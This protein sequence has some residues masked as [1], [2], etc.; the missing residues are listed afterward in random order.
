MTTN[1]KN[2]AGIRNGLKVGVEAHILNEY[3]SRYKSEAW[4]SSIGELIV[5][6]AG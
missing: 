4:E 3:K 2:F 5:L 1:E 6:A